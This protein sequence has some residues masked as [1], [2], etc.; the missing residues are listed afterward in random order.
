MHI[1]T[2][3]LNEIAEKIKFF[4]EIMGLSCTIVEL[5]ALKNRKV[6]RFLSSI[7]YIKPRAY[8]AW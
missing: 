6:S 5:C 8:S 1:S 3:K 7:G 4:G 2:T